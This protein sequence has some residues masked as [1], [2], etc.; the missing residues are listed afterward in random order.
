MTAKINENIKHIL[1]HTY[2]KKKKTFET[3]Y[4]NKKIYDTKEK[5]M[6]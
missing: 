5:K 3:L 6:S 2:K 4:E 1:C